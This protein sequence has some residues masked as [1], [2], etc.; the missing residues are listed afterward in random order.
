MK[1]W[2][3]STGHS[4]AVAERLEAIY[5]VLLK[6]DKPPMMIVDGTKIGPAIAQ[7]GACTHH[8]VTQRCFICNPRTT[9]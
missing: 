2:R 8:R 9:P 6:L 1:E 3:Y 5:E 4:C 7:V